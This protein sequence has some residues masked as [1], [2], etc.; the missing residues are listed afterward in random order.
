[1]EEF[2]NFIKTLW[3]NK[4]RRAALGLVFWVIFFIVVF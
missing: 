2:K 3:Q 1:M 4:R